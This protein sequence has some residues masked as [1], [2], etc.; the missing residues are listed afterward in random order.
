MPPCASGSSAERD[1][2][3][4][5]FI[6]KLAE[7]FRVRDEAEWLGSFCGRRFK[8]AEAERST[9]S[10]VRSMVSI[11]SMFPHGHGTKP[12]IA[13]IFTINLIRLI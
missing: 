6:S 8:A 9:P 11:K 7:G 13:E 3:D 2:K 4:Q 5:G 1:N 12:L 10:A